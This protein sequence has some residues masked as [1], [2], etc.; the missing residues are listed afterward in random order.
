MKKS[1][2][3][4][5][6][7]AGAAMLAGVDAL[8]AEAPGWQLSGNMNFQFYWIEQDYNT[9]FLEDSGTTSDGD[10]VSHIWVLALNNP[11]SPGIQDHGWYFGVD[12]AEIVLNVSG[13]A[14]NGLNYGFKIEFQAN[15]SDSLNADEARISLSGSWGSLLLGDEDGAEDVMNFGGEDLMG[16]T[17][18][19]DGDLDDVLLRNHRLFAGQQQW[20]APS[21]PTIAGDTGDSTK[22][23]YYT[24]R[25]SSFQLGASVTPTPNQG[26]SFKSDKGW[27][28]HYGI[29]A[30]YDNSF[31]DLLIRASAVY[32]MATSNAIWIND[33]SAWSIGGTVGWG[34]F[35]L[36]ANYTDNGDSGTRTLDGGD[37]LESESSYWD[38]AAGFETGR[39]YFSAGYFSSKREFAGPTAVDWTMDDSTMQTFSLTVD[40]TAAPGLG[41]YAE[42]DL[43]TDE[44]FG[45]DIDDFEWC[46]EYGVNQCSNDAT[47]FI[48][49]ASVTF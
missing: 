36:G 22:I 32:S 39:Y 29:G 1:L 2:L 3:G 15:T 26:D 5:T 43:I 46:E 25:F 14:D 41:F 4:G 33:T 9:A 12:E 11:N 37:G 21:Y 45:G 34:P 28:S 8:A 35:S 24:P 38:V 17:G 23:S 13:T 48:M 44:Y 20:A 19:F 30:N 7:L 10:P 18:G 31:G 27:E 42:I 16:A 47:V 49:G 40:Y 6:V